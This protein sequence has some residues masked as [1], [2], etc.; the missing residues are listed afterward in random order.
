MKITMAQLNPV[1]G[2]LAGNRA[3]AA[4]AY[5]AAA[6]AGSD[7][8]V[9]PEL[10]L[11]G[12]PPR[13]LLER[14]WFVKAAGAAAEAL[15]R[16]TAAHPGTG[17]LFGAPRP[18][19]RAGAGKPLYNAAVLAG[20]GRVLLEQ[21]KSLLP[22]YDVFDETRYF[23]PAPE[24]RTVAFKGE[25]L[26]ITVCED[27]WNDPALWP[28]GRLY[29]LD[30]VGVLAGKGAT[31]LV[32]IS[33][34]P[35]HAG[36]EETRFGLIRGHARRHGRPFV[37]VNQVGANDELVFDGRSFA[38]DGAGE[39]VA[40]GAAFREDVL[41]VDTGRPGTPG[42]F[43][44]LARIASVREALVLGLRDYMR[45]CGFG[46]A[47]VGLSGGIDSAV[48][49]CLAAEAVGP[50]NVLAV[51]MP[52]PFSS[53]GSVADSREL[54]ARLGVSCL[55]VPIAAV[56]EAYLAALGP[57]LAWRPADT[58]EENIQ[59]RIRGNILMAFSNKLGCL[60]LSTGNK[61]ELAVGYCTLYGDMSGGLAVLSDVPKTMVYEL[62]AFINAAGRSEI[63]PR[64]ILDK[65]PSA[66]L[67]PGQLDTDSLPPYPILDAILREYVEELRSVDEI[68][69]LG[70]EADVVRRVAGLVDRNEYKRAQAAPGIKVTAKA[71]GVGRRMPIASRVRLA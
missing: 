13:D 27:A 48:T 25:V 63:I 1:V 42:L 62:A 11:T 39:P 50:R 23:A 66:E 31:V 32:N 24:I 61:S 40:V 34:S 65:P 64:T 28:K 10:F 38:F 21:P 16:L 33:A 19:R 49:C 43:V 17:L 35:F 54:A 5:E 12:Y 51:T 20:D 37:F 9:L 58:A 70:F 59:A 29:G 30:P 7:L 69:A 52:M 57:H 14:P 67:R 36:K 46:R 47:V 60:V 4:S 22:A 8:V 44:P 3:A 53:P 26:G 6:K 18:A 41:T 2:D 71:F 15:V 45:K 56:Y 55:E 68:A